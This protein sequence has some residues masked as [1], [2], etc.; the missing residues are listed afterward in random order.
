[1]MLIG[2]I[3][4]MLGRNLFIIS[5]LIVI[6]LSALA[7]KADAATTPTFPLCA[8]PQGTV[9]VNYDNGTHGVAGD[10]NS[11]S[12]KDTVYTLSENTLIQCLCPANGNGVQTNWWKAGSL[13]TDEINVLISEGWILIPDGASWGLDVGPYLA[14]NSDYSCTSSGSGGVSDSKS[15]GGAILAT[16]TQAILSLANTGNTAFILGV[17][18]TGSLLLGSGIVGLL[19]KRG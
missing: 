13:T 19:R 5:W 7:G 4:Y 16:S 8:N 6:F 12:G 14:K 2:F 18:L 10:S 11:Y 15:G 1:M 3:F 17:F 9:R